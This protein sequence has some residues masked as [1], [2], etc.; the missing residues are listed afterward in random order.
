MKIYIFEIL[1][2][3]FQLK[4]RYRS[5]SSG[6]GVHNVSFQEHKYHNG[7]LIFQIIDLRFPYILLSREGYFIFGHKNFIQ[8]IDYRNGIYKL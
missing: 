8:K 7:N 6:Y 3:A 4:N 2:F 5:G 1:H